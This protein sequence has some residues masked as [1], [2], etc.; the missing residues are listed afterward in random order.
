MRSTLFLSIA[1]IVAGCGSSPAPTNENSAANANTKPAVNKA[2]TVVPIA[3]YTVVKSYPHDPDAFTQGLLYHDGF[4]YESTGQEGESTLRKV[5]IETGKVLQKHDLPDDVFAEGIALIN[6]QVYQL[7][8]RNRTGWVY[9]VNDFKLLREFSYAGEGWGLT[10][11]GTN[12]YMSDGTHVIRVVNP[13]DFKTVRTITV[14]DEAGKPLMMLN[15]LEFIK[16]EIWANV[17]HSE[18]I[19][20]P[21]HIARIDPETGKLLGW[22]DL[23]GISPDDQ[24]GQAKSEHT[25]NGIAYDEANDRI[26]VTGKL[27][28]KLYE[29]K[30]VQQ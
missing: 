30:L 18:E 29:I 23:S 16:G 3:G 9:D 13:A 22:I 14:K 28:K 1:L 12:L 21:N 2:A 15:E 24:T 4:L 19:G 6:G 17:W 25:L 11:D 8:W 5:E 27:W 7:S 26:F 10:E 20:K